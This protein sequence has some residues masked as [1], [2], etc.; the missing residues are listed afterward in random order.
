MTTEAIAEKPTVP[1]DAVQELA[2]KAPQAASLGG[3]V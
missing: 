2:D 1:V 3:T